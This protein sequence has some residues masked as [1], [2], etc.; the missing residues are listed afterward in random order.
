MRLRKGLRTWTTRRPHAARPTYLLDLDHTRISLCRGPPR[1]CD[2]RGDRLRGFRGAIEGRGLDRGSPT[3]S[4]PGDFTCEGPVTRRSTALAA[5]ASPL[6]RR[7]SEQRRDGAGRRH[8]AGPLVFRVPRDLSVVSFDDTPTVRMSVPSLTAIIRQ[9]IAAM[10]A[11]RP[12]L[13]IESKTQAAST[14]IGRFLCPSI[15]SSALDWR[16]APAL[17]FGRGRR[18]DARAVHARFASP[19]RGFILLYALGY[20]GFS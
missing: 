5:L 4:Q 11:R 8:A 6:A 15:S 18:A 17:S 3:I 7:K 13:L 9:P 14:A 20:A 10:T 16:A 1:I 12:R 19:G 2:Q